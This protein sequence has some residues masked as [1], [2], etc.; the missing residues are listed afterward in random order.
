MHMV[1]MLVCWGYFRFVLLWEGWESRYFFDTFACLCCFA[2]CSVS[3]PIFK[4]FGDVGKL[5]S[6]LASFISSLGEDLEYL[7]W[8]ILSDFVLSVWLNTS[9]SLLDRFP[10]TL[11]I[12]L[13]N[14]VMGRI[15]LLNPGCVSL[16]VS[17][18]AFVCLLDLEEFCF[19]G[20]V[21]F[22]PC[23]LLPLNH[24][25]SFDLLVW[26][27]GVLFNAYI[28]MHIFDN[29]NNPLFGND[30]TICSPSE[31]IEWSFCWP[32]DLRTIRLWA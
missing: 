30:S 14:F 10:C 27:G 4:D 32:W 1:F 21:Y 26:L 6:C 22:W 19:M 23:V 5:Q 29:S 7:L 11:S 18:P 13:D 17:N 20:M 8:V 15:V 12:V 24:K 3:R 9:L 25:S 16:L 31:V 2:T 28:L